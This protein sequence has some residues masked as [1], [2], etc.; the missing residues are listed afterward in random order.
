M[1]VVVDAGERALAEEDDLVRR[2]TE[3]VV[4]LIE[5]VKETSECASD[6]WEGG[7]K[8]S[9]NGLKISLNKFQ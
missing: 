5:W 7:V 1:A 8:K 4:L 9:L 6:G 2:K 3:V